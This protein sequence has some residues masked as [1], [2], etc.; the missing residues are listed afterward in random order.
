MKARFLL[1]GLFIWIIGT[2][3]VRLAGQHIL[4]PGRWRGMLIL[5]AVS[6]PLMALLVRRICVGSKIPPAEWADG[7]IAIMLPTLLLDPFSSAFFPT[8]FPNI[9]PSMAGAFGGWML[10]CCAGAALGVSFRRR[11]PS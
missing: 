7:A 9:A 4:Q 5:Y 3:A 8:V 6:F 10:F 11:T 2:L 1:T